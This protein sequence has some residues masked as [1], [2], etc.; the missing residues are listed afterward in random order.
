MKYLFLMMMLSISMSVL[1]NDNTI[2]STSDTSDDILS[3]LHFI[4]HLSPDADSVMSAIAAAKLY[5]GVASISGKLDSESSFVFDFISRNKKKGLVLPPIVRVTDDENKLLPEFERGISW[6]LVDCHQSAKLPINLDINCIQKIID[7]HSITSSLIKNPTLKNENIDITPRGSTCT[8]L[9]LK[10]FESKK[11]I[12]PTYAT[13]LLSGII[14][15]T[16]FLTMKATTT[17]LDFKMFECLKEIAAIDDIKEFAKKMF[18]ARTSAIEKLSH[19]SSTLNKLLLEDYK[20]FQT[21]NKRVALPAVETTR[22]LELTQNLNLEVNK[23]EI[24]LQMK[25]LKEEN[26]LDHIFFAVI[27]RMNPK[28]YLFYLD[29]DELLVKE[30]FQESPE[31]FS[32]NIYYIPK[33]NARTSE[34][35]AQI[36]REIQNR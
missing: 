21:G 34:I 18:E 28:T 20:E 17:D 23:R 24:L 3:N 5:N 35:F 12:S 22:A 1:S 9:A 8:M 16:N 32:D 13:I 26:K 36:E 19:S 14:S 15:D 29:E 27:D 7:H 6:G 31:I 10:F 33:K 2:S 25:K 4:G 11:K 30:S